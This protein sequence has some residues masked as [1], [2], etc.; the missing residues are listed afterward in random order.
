MKRQT[1]KLPRHQDRPLMHYS[2]SNVTE[3]SGFKETLY[4]LH[5]RPYLVVDPFQIPPERLI[6]ESLRKEKETK[7]EMATVQ[8]IFLTSVSIFAASV[9]SLVAYFKY[10]I[11]IIHYWIA[12][13]LL[14]GSAFIALLSGYVLNKCHKEGFRL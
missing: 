2:V 6:S 3:E 13:P 11:V 7:E 4:E 14:I 10:N 12:V 5:S 8:R 1:E 9:L